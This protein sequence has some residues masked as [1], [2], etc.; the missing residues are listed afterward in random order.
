VSGDEIENDQ[1]ECIVGPDLSPISDD[2]LNRVL[3]APLT[4]FH[5]LTAI[6]DCCHSGTG[7][8]LPWHVVIPPGAGVVRLKA[9]S[10]AAAG[11]GI[12]G[13]TASVVCMSGCRATQTSADLASDV[14]SSHRAQG[15]LTDAL[16]A[17]LGREP[18]MDSLALKQRLLE[19]MTRTHLAQRPQ[20]TVSGVDVINGPFLCPCRAAVVVVPPNSVDVRSYDQP[21]QRG[22]GGGGGS[23]SRSRSHTVQFA[24]PWA[25]GDGS[26]SDDDEGGYASP[27]RYGTRSG[28][29]TAAVRQRGA[30][31][32]RGP[33]GSTV[34]DERRYSMTPNG[35]TPHGC[36]STRLLRRSESTANISTRGG[37]QS[38]RVLHR[39]ESSG[40]MPTYRS[41]LATG[42]TTHHH[43]GG[44]RLSDLSPPPPSQWYAPMGTTATPHQYRK[45]KRFPLNRHIDP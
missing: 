40:H 4:S 9:A 7:L 24:S 37:G 12:R 29:P 22:G 38:R 39:S 17:I 30:S 13:P 32:A 3:V 8:D 15:A 1:D 33:G 5:S 6:L 42:T 20:L 2:Q 18:S 26:P 21:V 44:R 27:Q 14:T 45:E 11:V 34:D 41:L 43:G 28:S 25:P 36:Q 35:Y 10:P 16:C 31:W 23:R 19:T